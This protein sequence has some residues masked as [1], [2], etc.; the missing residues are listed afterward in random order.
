MV[1]KRNIPGRWVSQRSLKKATL[2]PMAVWQSVVANTIKKSA[3]CRNHGA[4]AAIIV[5][6]VSVPSRHETR[7]DEPQRK[8]DDFPQMRSEYPQR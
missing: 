6:L 1:E 7:P 2:V 5:A 3:L 8:R 4:V